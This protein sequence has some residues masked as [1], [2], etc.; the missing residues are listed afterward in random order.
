MMGLLSSIGN[1]VKNSIVGKA[2]DTLSVAVAHPV[3]TIGAIISPDKTVKDVATAHFSQPLGKQ[4]TETVIGGAALIGTVAGGAAVAG[5]ARAGTLAPTAISV[6]KSLIPETTKGKVIAAVATPVVV[7][8]VIN[9]PK[10][11][12]QA[13]AET[14]GN[15]AN[16]GGNV[17]N[18]VAEPSKEN[19]KTLV[20]ENPL[21]T[22]GAGAA[23]ALIVGKGVAS[24]VATVSN[25]MAVKE[26]TKASQDTPLPT[27]AA[28]LPETKTSS[29]AVAAAPVASATPVTPETKPLLATAGGSSTSGTRRKARKSTKPTA[30]NQKVNILI[31]NKSSSVGIANK[32][33]IK[34]AILAR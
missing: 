8:A 14:P 17:A 16:F 13:V 4:I 28:A 31:N 5:A 33:F 34:E 20:Q 19:L 32:K 22:A 6:G 24:T 3:Q 26:N 29:G 7:G 25:T 12:A 30:I 23:A 11:V 2:L 21:I 15:L 18:L 9:Q 27:V 10:A 1:K